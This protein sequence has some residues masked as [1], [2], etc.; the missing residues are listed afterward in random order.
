MVKGSPQLSYTH[1]R[2]KVTGDPSPPFTQAADLQKHGTPKSLDVKTSTVRVVFWNARD[3]IAV[4]DAVRVR[5]RVRRP[6]TWW[7]CDVH[8][9]GLNTPGHC[10]H[11]AA[12]A[13]TPVPTTGPAQVEPGAS[14][15]PGPAPIKEKQ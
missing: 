15:V 6:G 1:I 2:E 13:A 3:V 4:V 5:I 7:V 8:G 12:L 10:R 14:R 11:T 9:R